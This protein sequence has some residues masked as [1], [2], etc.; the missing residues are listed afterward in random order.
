MKKILFLATAVIVSFSVF[1]QQNPCSPDASLQDST[2][3]LWPDTV[4]N[5]P[6]SQ[7][8]TYYEEHIQ[9]KTP[10]TVGEVMGDPYEIFV[11]GFPVNIAPLEIDSI[12]LVEVM[13][14]PSI[15]STYLSNEDSVFLGN[16]IACVTLFGTPGDAELGTHNISLIIDGWISVAG[17]GTVSLY[18]QLGDYESI[19]GYMIYGVGTQSGSVNVQNEDLQI[20]VGTA[21]TFLFGVY[22]NHRYVDS[23]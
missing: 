3:G 20:L 8:D 7:V 22:F 18:D 21:N 13:G 11:L 9:I 2:F 19:D 4:Q 15:M 12:K 16:D 6:I 14:L 17:L 1:A 23:I 5:L 10:A